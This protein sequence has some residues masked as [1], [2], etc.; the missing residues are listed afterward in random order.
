MS[1]LIETQSQLLEL[2][3]IMKNT[4][5]LLQMISIRILHIHMNC[6]IMLSMMSVL[7]IMDGLTCVTKM[8]RTHLHLNLH[9]FMEVDMIVAV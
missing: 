9:S 5:K 8:N 1:I 2:M 4:I 3:I 7:K 6:L